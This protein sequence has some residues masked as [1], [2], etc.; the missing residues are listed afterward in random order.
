MA[1]KSIFQKLNPAATKLVSELAASKDV[2]YSPWFADIVKAD[3]KAADS[4][5]SA[6]R[7]FIVNQ[8]KGKKTKAAT[9][10]AKKKV[11]K[12]K[13]AK[14]KAKKKHVSTTAIPRD[15]D[16]S[17]GPVG[18]KLELLKPALTI[19]KML[20]PLE[21][22]DRDRVLEAVDNLFGLDSGQ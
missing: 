18:D 10:K 11:A 4:N 16:R 9:P 7:A 19:V 13:T 5:P 14:R 17:N 21:R 8:R 22:G 6:L 12:K 15:V 1:F 20:A 2:D 3:K